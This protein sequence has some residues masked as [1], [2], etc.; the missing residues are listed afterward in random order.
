MDV[1]LSPVVP[2]PFLL[3]LDLC[4]L[5]WLPLLSSSLLPSSLL[6]QALLAQFKQMDADLAK[7]TD[8]VV[9]APSPRAAATFVASPVPINGDEPLVLYG[10]EADTGRAHKTYGDL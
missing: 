2:P 7:P 10:G 8:A 4:F 5:S 1:A 3:V 9:S 6:G